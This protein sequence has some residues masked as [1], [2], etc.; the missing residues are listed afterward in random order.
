MQT[1]STIKT[2]FEIKLYNVKNCYK[3]NKNKLKENKANYVYILGCHTRN[4][5][6][7]KLQRDSRVATSLAYK[8]G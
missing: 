7:D 2:Y 5:K 6:E 1:T 8:D 4:T 3:I